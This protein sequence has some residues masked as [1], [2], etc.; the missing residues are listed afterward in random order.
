MQQIFSKQADG[1]SFFQLDR[2]TFQIIMRKKF[3]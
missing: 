1:L 3:N 2:A